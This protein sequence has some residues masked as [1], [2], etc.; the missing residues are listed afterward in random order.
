MTVLKTQRLWLCHLC[1]FTLPATLLALTNCAAPVNYDVEVEIPS[2][3]EVALN[4][5]DETP[6]D[7]KLLDIGVL[8]FGTEQQASVRNQIGENVFA[9]VRDNERHLLPFSLRKILV[10]S[11]QWGAVRV[12]PQ[13]DPSVDLLID[14]RILQSDGTQLQLAVTATD[15]SGRQWLNKTYTDRTLA[16]DFP[17]STDFRNR[18]RRN[19]SAVSEPF[20]DLYEQIANDLLMARTELS[21]NQ[22]RQISQISQMLYA[23]DL[24]EESFGDNIQRT[25]DGQVTIV[26]LPPINDPMMRRVHE[27]RERHYLFI[28]TVDEYYEALYEDMRDSYLLWRRYSFDQILEERAA[29]QRAVTQERYSSSSGYLTLTQRYDRYRW[30]KIYEL[31]YRELA[32]GFNRE[33]APAILELNQQVHGLSGTMEEQYLQ[34]RRVLRQLFAL[35]NDAR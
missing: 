6:E 18:N 21:E 3:G 34:W 24:S 5:S 8:I 23:A 31:E 15:S 11:N 16:T 29:E 7:W 32:S 35:E 17:E 33:A 14:G 10:D 28:D 2:V 19:L 26:S 9:E 1:H 27:M 30:S 20:T 12:L 25:E 13:A 4:S 22:V